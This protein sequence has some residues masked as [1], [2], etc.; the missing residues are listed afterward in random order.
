MATY[1]QHQT[2][3]VSSTKT[4]SLKYKK[5]V[6]STK[7]TSLKYKKQVSGTKT[8]S[9]KYKQQVSST[10]ATSLK[11]K[12]N[13]SQVQKHPPFYAKHLSHK[14]KYTNPNLLHDCLSKRP[15]TSQEQC[16]HLMQNQLQ[17]FCQDIIAMCFESSTQGF[18]VKECP[19]RP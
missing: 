2:S 8:K 1:K 4:T 7:T 15:W 5:Q 16:L 18:L 3:Q 10:K 6:S 14:A 19:Y 11:Y 9:P 12:N 13:K 17:I